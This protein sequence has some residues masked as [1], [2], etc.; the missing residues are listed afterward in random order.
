MKSLEEKKLL[1]K[2]ARMLGQPVDQALVE[3]IEREE[4]LAAAFF[5]ESKESE[6]PISILREDVL[7]EVAP[8]E[9]LPPQ[10]EKP[11]ETNIQPPE[12]YKVQQVK[13]YLDTV[14]KAKTPPLV[15]ALQDNELQALR[16][17]VKDLLSKVNT[18]SWGGGG[19]GIVRLWNA[20]DLD[21]ST[22]GNNKVVKYRTN[23]SGRFYFDTVTGLEDFTYGSFS[24]TTNQTANAANTPYEV[25]FNTTDSSKGHYIRNNTE[26]VANVAG[27]YNYQFSMQLTST[28]ASLDNVYIWIRKNNVDVPNTATIVSLAQNKQYAVAA[29]NFF[30][31]MNAGDHIHLMWAVTDTR[32]SI[33]APAAT[34]F[35]PAVP[36]V[37]LTVNQINT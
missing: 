24:D 19:T 21:R 1:V 31:G 22:A 7:T 34:S 29:W 16:K 8:I 27:I 13:N 30:V 33:A 12:E 20:D 36:S 10:P 32:L 6:P 17:T 23:D 3:S 25:S 37:I 26:I 14:S 2:M 35:C 28:S 9:K 4:K 15:T 11:A 18:L 5:G